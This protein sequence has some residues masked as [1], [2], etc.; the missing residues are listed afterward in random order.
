MA[1]HASAIKKNRQDIKRRAR[2][3]MHAGR[4]RTQVKKA[5]KAIESGDVAAASGMMRETVALVDR[6]ASHGILHRNAAARTKSRL[7]K[8]LARAQTQTK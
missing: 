5:R 6:S 1:S 7:A 8:A 3:R 4:L 2:N